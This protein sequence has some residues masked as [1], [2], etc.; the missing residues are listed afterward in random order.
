MI[1][2]SIVVPVYNAESTI[3]RCVESIISNKMNKI[4]I[5][6]V[7]DCSKDNSFQICMKLA[8]KYNEVKVFHNSKNKGVSHTRNVGIYAAK[9]Q[10]T[11]FVDS[12]DWVDDSYYATFDQFT[13][14]YPKSL[15]IC[16]YVNHDEK[17]NGRTDTIGWAEFG[18]YKITNI[19]DEIENIYNNN[20]LQQ[21]WN[22]IFITDII[23]KNN[24]R[25]DESISIGEDL[26]FILEYIKVSCFDTLIL[27]NKPLYHYMRDQ[28]GSLMYQVGN[29][30]IE[31]PLKN[32]R[33]LYEI[34]GLS[35]EETEKR[36]S[37][38]REK[39]VKL[40]AYLILHNAGMSLK[41]RKKLVY[42]LD[43]VQGKKLYKKNRNI[44][45]KEKLSKLLHK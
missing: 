10:Y 2:Y 30:S 35:N 18:D 44:L 38:D 14:K 17:H 5:I 16:G 25:F 24:L 31:E 27:I 39:Q 45:I 11:M 36:L 4:E 34:I 8:E 22:K 12:D 42:N 6:L 19:N 32:L 41:Q 13:D 3:E 9:G 37:Q 28:N 33:S 7:D 21:L 15:M 26:R 23:Q 29:E 43:S 20:L 1:K 40:Y